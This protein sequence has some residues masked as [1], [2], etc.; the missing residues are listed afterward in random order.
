M[1]LQ[2]RLALAALTL[3]MLPR[4]RLYLQMPLHSLLFRDVHLTQVAKRVPNAAMLLHP[5]PSATH[6]LLVGAQVASPGAQ[7]AV[8]GF[9][10]G[11]CGNLGVKSGGCFV[12]GEFE[13]RGF[14]DGL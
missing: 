11:H 9:A 14:S 2:P 13:S 3:R 12:D 7:V 8:A 1:R 10:G 4:P 6:P 5:V